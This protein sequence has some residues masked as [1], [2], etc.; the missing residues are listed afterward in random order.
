MTIINRVFYIF[1][2]LQITFNYSFLHSVVFFPL[3]EK[4]N[5]VQHPV[6]TNSSK[7]QDYFNQGL[8]FYYAFNH[9]AAYKSFEEAAE[10]DPEMSMAYWGMALACGPIMGVEIPL[11]QEEKAYEAIQKA[12]LLS[13][14][15]PGVEKAY[16]H[17]LAKRYTNDS[18]PNFSQLELSYKNAQ[19]EVMQNYP[20]DLDAA[21]L[22]AESAINLN[23][24][25]LW[26]TSGDP[27]EGTTELVNALLSVI[28]RDPMNIGGNHFYIL[29]MENS[30]YPERAATSAD[31]LAEV[32]PILSQLVNSA[33]HIYIATGDYQKSIN[34]NKKAILGDR[35]YIEIFGPKKNAN[36][37]YARNLLFLTRSYVMAGNFEEAIKNANDLRDVYYGNYENFPNLELYYSIPLFV[38]I[39]FEQW[40]KILEVKIPPASLKNSQALWHY[41]RAIAFAALGNRD[42][43]LVEKALIRIPDA[44]NKKEYLQNEIKLLEYF[45]FAKM[46]ETEND[47][48]SAIHYYQKAVDLDDKIVSTP[49]DSLL[50]W[51]EYLGKALLL[52]HQYK[53]A[54]MVFREDLKWHA[55]NGRSLL[56]LYY[57]LISQAR[58]YD[59]FWVKR[60]FDRAWKHSDVQLEK[61]V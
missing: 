3:F 44:K 40:K 47:L 51:R 41:S 45:L 24:K 13:T 46:A 26:K 27:D 39:C 28:K 53:E 32:A 59:A 12:I 19:K 31:A 30:I 2:V 14:K 17:A 15:S 54:E 6:T 16:I 7:A 60:E 42:Q 57:S 9:D 50:I 43:A 22:F 61:E 49:M 4:I 25:H 37:N 11:S 10:I 5:Y 21:N 29:A 36:F 52:N 8:S 33:S 55:R 1:L 58:S 20:D 38:L 48:S 34:V 56:G 35:V 18:N 23:P